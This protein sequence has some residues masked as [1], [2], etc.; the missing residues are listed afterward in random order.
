M[1]D[2]K[3]CKSP[4]CDMRG[5][6]EVT[7]YGYMPMTNGDY[8]RSM[9]DEEMVKNFQFRTLCGYIKENESEWCET[10]G[11][12]ANCVSRWLK[13]PRRTENV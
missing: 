8:V 4:M 5:K 9:N 11:S 1:M 7:C 2:C 13:Q 12:C 3:S 10:N 6:L